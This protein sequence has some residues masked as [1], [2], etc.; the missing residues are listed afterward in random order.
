VNND[1]KIFIIFSVTGPFLL[2]LVFG[3]IE[4]SCALF[5][6]AHISYCVSLE[7]VIVHFLFFGQ[8]KGLP[9]FH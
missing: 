5:K 6:D 3:M 1:V 8:S 7:V 4:P 2:H 9:T